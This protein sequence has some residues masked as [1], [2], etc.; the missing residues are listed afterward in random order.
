MLKIPYRGKS[1]HIHDVS[2]IFIFVA[3]VADVQIIQING[4]ESLDFKTFWLSSTIAAIILFIIFCLV[5]FFEFVVKEVLVQQL[6]ACKSVTVIIG[7]G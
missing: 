6:C 4:T 3:S 7:R 1:I 2:R 5:S